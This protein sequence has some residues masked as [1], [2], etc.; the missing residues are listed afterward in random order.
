MKPTDVTS[1]KRACLN[2][3]LENSL[4]NFRRIMREDIVFE[5]L[6]LQNGMFH[7]TSFSF[8]MRKRK[9]EEKRESITV[10]VRY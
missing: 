9:E 2:D 8:L 6:A 5:K 7:K 3:E 4:G 10:N 1:K